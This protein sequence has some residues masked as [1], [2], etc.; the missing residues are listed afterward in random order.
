MAEFKDRIALVTGA[1]RGIGSAAARALARRGARVA[2]S[3]RTV[4]DLEKIVAEM[5]KEG[6]QGLA[7]A[8]DVTE[9]DQI[10]QMVDRV[11]QEWGR[12]DIFVNNAGRGSPSLAVEEVSIEDWERTMTLNLR[13]AFLC[14]RAVVPVMK[15][16]GYGR[17]VIV[18]SLAGR[19]YGRLTSLQYGTA[20]AG[21]IGLARNLAVQ[22]GPHGICV[23][24]VTPSV[25]ATTRVKA[26]VDAMPEE[27]RQRLLAGIPLRRLAEPEEV[28]AAIAFLASDDASYITG[29]SLDV[30]GGTYMA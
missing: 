8:C 17:I 7:V 9:P 23:N 10:H 18:S 22:L 30:N 13:S 25:V 2:V 15:R 21:L 29:V 20:K 19:S 5:K 3:S 27:D 6:G 26:Q 11:V 14:V 28:A 24:A 1:S 4:A 12:L 16:Q